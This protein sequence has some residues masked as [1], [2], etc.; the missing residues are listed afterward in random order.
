MLAVT[1]ARMGKDDMMGSSEQIIYE[2]AVSFVVGAGAGFVAQYWPEETCFSATALGGVLQLL[3][4]MCT[5]SLENRIFSFTVL[6]KRR[7]FSR[8]LNL[9]SIHKNIQKFQVLGWYTLSLKS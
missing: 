3:R 8:C 2:S 4:G 7:N 5:L 9:C 1:V 6:V